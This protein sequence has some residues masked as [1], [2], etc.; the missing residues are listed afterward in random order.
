[1]RRLPLL[2]SVAALAVV[3]G[4]ACARGVDFDPE[5][6]QT[7][8]VNVINEMPHPMVVWFDDGT[9]ERLLGTVDAQ[10]RDRFVIPGTTAGTVSVIARDEGTT[11][12]VRRTVSLIPGGSV[13]VRLN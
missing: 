10:S 8:T 3:V 4:V 5:L 9:G 7:H 11:H 13:D 6:A 12:T 2:L 1:M